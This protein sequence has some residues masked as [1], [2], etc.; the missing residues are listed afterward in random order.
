MRTTLDIPEAT[1]AQAQKILGYK[2][3]TDTVIFSLNE[4]I[5]RKKVNELKDL[6][7]KIEIKVDLKKSRRRAK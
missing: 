5:R 1:M 4:L 2:S 6:A 7:G 3:K